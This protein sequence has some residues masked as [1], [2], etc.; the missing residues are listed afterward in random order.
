MFGRNSI[1]GSVKW[2]GVPNFLRNDGPPWTLNILAPDANLGERGYSTN[3]NRGSGSG[4]EL[5]QCC[6]PV[7]LARPGPSSLPTEGL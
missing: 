4:G 6:Y 2:I 5:R 7:E 1:N 3:Q